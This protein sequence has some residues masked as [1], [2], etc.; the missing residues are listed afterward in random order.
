MVPP[1]GRLWAIAL[2]TRLVVIWS[3]SAGEPVVVAAVPVVSIVV[4]RFSASGSSVSVAS[5]ARRDRSTGSRTK[6]PVSAR[7]SES[8]ASVRS[9]ARV[10][11][12]CSRST[13]STGSRV[14]S[15]RASSSMVCVTASGVRSSW[16]ALAANRCCSSTCASR[17]ASIASKLSA[18]S[19]NSSWRPSSSMRW[20]SEPED[21]RR[22]AAVIR[23]R[24][25]SIRPA[26]NHPPTRPDHQQERHRLRGPRRERRQ[27][28][29]PGGRER[30]RAEERLVRHVA[31]QEHPHGGEQQRAG[32]Q[33]EAGVAQG[34]PHPHA[35]PRRPS[36]GAARHRVR[37]RRRRCGSP[38][39]GRW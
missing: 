4:A 7:L 37:P 25:A 28:V 39:P 9:I 31:Q 13:S 6:T 22:V 3:R 32:G 24:G 20:D 30:S 12:T 19:R 21:A 14:G 26:R 38:R 16:E 36:H 17:R 18:S 15:R 27:Q 34:E 2:W 33:E 10:L 5:S 11:T 8:S 1:S 23:S 35:Q 29:R